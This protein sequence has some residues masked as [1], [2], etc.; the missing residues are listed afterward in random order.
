VS[1]TAA[2]EKWSGAHLARAGEGAL[3]LWPSETLVRIFRGR[4]VPGL[5]RD[6]R[7]T[8]VLDV[9]CGDGN[10]LLLYASLGMHISAT[11]VTEE[12]C[13]LVRSRL[14]A[15][16]CEVDARV[17]CNRE[18]PFEDDRFDFLVS[19]NVLHYE[20]ND[21]DVQSAVAEY[22][23]VLKPGGRVVISTTG[24]DHLILAGAARLGPHRYR[25]EID[26]FR[27]G[28]V[29]FYFERPESLRGRLEKSFDDV[30][31]GRDRTELF[32][33]NVDFFIATGVKR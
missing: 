6:L 33:R 3:H 32:S 20:S 22:A 29:F 18:L 28:Q 7:G 13:G 27:R 16:G 23:R 5:A 14:A 30:L 11:E 21:S 17:G 12:V 1:A 25:I 31:V 4:F 15:M 9:G 10:N 24:P 19:W 8:S 2:F 26:D